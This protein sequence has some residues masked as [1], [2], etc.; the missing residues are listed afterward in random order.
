MRMHFKEI[1]IKGLA[2]MV[3]ISW[4]LTSAH[5]DEIQSGFFIESDLR[6]NYFKPVNPPLLRAE[7]LPYYFQRDTALVF[8]ATSLLGTIEIGNAG[9]DTLLLAPP[10]EYLLKNLTLE[11]HQPNSGKRAIIP[12]LIYYDNDTESINLPDWARKKS[13]VPGEKIVISTIYKWDEL[14]KLGSGAIEFC[15]VLSN[16]NWSKQDKNIF[17]I[18]FK[19][20]FFAFEIR[21]LSTK[22]DSLYYYD[23]QAQSG[24][25]NDNFIES[26]DFSNRILRIDSTNLN[27]FRFAADALWKMNRFDEAIGY[28]QAGIDLLESRL[29][30]KDCLIYEYPDFYRG[31]MRAFIDKCQRREKWKWAQ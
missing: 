22:W 6:A 19:S 25:V 20:K 12:N 7:E 14:V 2:A 17:P 30:R 28:A 29:V 10:G 1:T 18:D 16:S 31:V 9:Q 4:A 11:Y 27:A 15:W 21:A 24:D 8:P 23:I 13:L 26:L 5:S 3:V